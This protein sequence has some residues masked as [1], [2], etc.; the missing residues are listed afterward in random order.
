VRWRRRREERGA[1]DKAVNNA[2][3]RFA[4]ALSVHDGATS[5]FMVSRELHPIGRSTPMLHSGV[6]EQRHPMA[7]EWVPGV[8]QLRQAARR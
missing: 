5:V 7:P 4:P 8:L 1:A 6:L 2:G 3:W